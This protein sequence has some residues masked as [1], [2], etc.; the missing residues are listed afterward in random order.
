MPHQL[1]LKKKHIKAKLYLLL[2]CTCLSD[3]IRCDKKIQKPKN[4]GD[5]TVGTISQTTGTLVVYI[6]SDR[7]HKIEVQQACCVQWKCPR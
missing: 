6:V 3:E 1:Y 2:G 4:Q 7:S 5:R